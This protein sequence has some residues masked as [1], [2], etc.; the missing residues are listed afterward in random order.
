[1]TILLAVIHAMSKNE[2]FKPEMLYIGT[3]FID[4]AIVGGLI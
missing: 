1:M 3:F 4:L 2:D